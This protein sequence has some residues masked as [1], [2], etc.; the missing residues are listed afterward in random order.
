MNPANHALL[1]WARHITRAPARRYW[2]HA[3]FRGSKMN[4]FRRQVAIDSMNRHSRDEKL[5]QEAADRRT[6]R[7]WYPWIVA[8]RA[9]AAAA[10]RVAKAQASL[11]YHK[12]HQ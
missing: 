8:S 12:A 10:A 7:A 6:L 3:D 11:R 9:E 1:S 2:T 4:H 5:S